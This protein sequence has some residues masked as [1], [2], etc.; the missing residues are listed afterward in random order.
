MY[1]DDKQLAGK[2]QIYVEILNKE[3]DLGCTQLQ[4]QISKDI[5]DN[6]RT[7]NFRG[8]SRE[9]TIPSKSSLF[10]MVL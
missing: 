4:C 1:V 8:W 3:F 6:Y 2:K 9:I 10:F 5:V 7:V